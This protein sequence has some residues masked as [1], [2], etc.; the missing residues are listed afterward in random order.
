MK[1]TDPSS[2]R[3]NA[4]FVYWE[5]SD[6]FRQV[7]APY[8]ENWELFKGSG[9]ADDLI[10]AGLLVPHEE[11]SPN[12]A[13]RPDAVA[14]LKPERVPF[15]SYPYE[16]S[17]SQ[18]KDAALCTLQLQ[19]RALA[20]GMSLKDATA[21]NVQFRAG[22]PLFI[23]TLSF[24]KYEEGKPWIAYGQFC[25]HFLAPLAMMAMVS[26]EAGKLMVAFLDG[27]PLPMA[28]AA[29]PGKTKLKP[30]LAL[31]LHLHAKAVSKAGEGGGSS[32][33]RGVSKTGLMGLLDS[34]ESTIQ[35]LSWKPEGTVWADYYSETN[36]SDQSMQEKRRLVGEFLEAAGAGGKV[37]WDLGANTGEFSAIA[38]KTARQVYAWDI[39]PGA[40][41]RH[42][43]AVREKKIANVLP[44][45]QDLTNPSPGIGWAN[46]ERASF[47]DRSNADVLLALA[48]V[49][50]LAIGENVPLP[51][52]ASFFAQL[53]PWLIIEFVPKSDSQTK[54]LLA[55]RTD[56]FD[57]YTEEGFESAFRETHRQV[58]KEPIPGTERT[59]Y[60]WE[61]ICD[62]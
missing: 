23:D 49:H 55:S 9:L 51:N 28:S 27:I 40:V 20:K 12:G 1:I 36:Y 6:L 58:R 35:G 30:G 32:G 38:A 5:G 25:R 29:L 11:L 13:P 44:L 14:I 37:V 4:G 60:L 56:I 16:W 48:L 54:R 26:P 18:L 42:Y 10:S 8:R 46:R 39:D 52:V 57:R 22:R 47:A 3:D 62:S 53:G 15:I 43:L 41:E 45:I 33:A 61:R 50:H 7:C 21:Y 31:H 24:E 2:F 17:F 59:L 19:K 34:L